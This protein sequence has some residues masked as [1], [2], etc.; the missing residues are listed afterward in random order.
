MKY[1]YTCIHFYH[2]FKQKQNSPI[3][4]DYNHCKLV[5]LPCICFTSVISSLKKPH[6]AWSDTLKSQG[7]RGSISRFVPRYW[8]A[9]PL[10]WWH[11]VARHQLQHKDVHLL[12]SDMPCSKEPQS[13]RE[14]SCSLGCFPK[15]RAKVS[16]STDVLISND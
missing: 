13:F 1:V 3:S 14:W 7:H 4:E 5:M 16:E 11:P 8:Q 15:N 9:P 6:L 12:V 10:N 2:H